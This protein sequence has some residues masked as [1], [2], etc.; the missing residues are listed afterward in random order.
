MSRHLLAPATRLPQDL[1]AYRLLTSDEAALV[2]CV[3]VATLRMWRSR[4]RGYGPR[5]VQVGASIRY[6]LVDLL[7]WI[8]DHTATDVGELPE[9]IEPSRRGKASPADLR[10]LTRRRRPARVAPDS[11]CTDNPSR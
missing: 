8:D 5:A 7:A 11:S 6:R 10:S 3:P 2:L 1:A 4:R 9:G